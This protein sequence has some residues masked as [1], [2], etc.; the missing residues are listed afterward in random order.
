M[1]EWEKKMHPAPIKPYSPKTLQKKRDTMC[2]LLS[3]TFLP[4]YKLPVCKCPQ[5]AGFSGD[6][7]GVAHV[8][9]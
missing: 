1:T 6:V 4:G 7:Y 9:R 2:A 5:A 8:F 3:I